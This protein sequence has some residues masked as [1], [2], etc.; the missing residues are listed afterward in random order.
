MNEIEP[1]QPRPV[2]LSHNQRRELGKHYSRPFFKAGQL[3]CDVCG[4]PVQD[5]VDFCANSAGDPGKSRFYIVAHCHGECAEMIFRFR[6]WHEHGYEGGK[7]ITVFEKGVSL[8]E[9]PAPAPMVI[10]SHQL[11]LMDRQPEPSIES[12]VDL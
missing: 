10:Q 8:P 3:W 12:K 11:M 9:P 4:K 7:R 1:S 5:T 6:D 2:K